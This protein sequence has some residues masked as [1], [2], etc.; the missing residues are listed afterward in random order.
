[1][2]DADRLRH[3]LT[4]L[5]LTQRGLARQLDVDER[6]VRRYCAGDVAVP[7]V[8]WLALDAL[9]AQSGTGPSPATTPS[10]PDR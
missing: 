7:R 2:T 5:G 3:R 4:A 8:V 10:T 6:T 1:M 9:T